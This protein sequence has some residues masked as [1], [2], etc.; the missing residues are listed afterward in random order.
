[1]AKAAIRKLKMRRFWRWVCVDVYGKPEPKQ[2]IKLCR[3]RVKFRK[4]TFK[5]QCDKAFAHVMEMID[6]KRQEMKEAGR[7][8]LE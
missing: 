8:T 2:P 6:A 5:R 3:K 4:G 7:S 1:M